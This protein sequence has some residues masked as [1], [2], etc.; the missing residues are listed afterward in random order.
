M[1]SDAADAWIVARD[2][3]LKRVADELS[4]KPSDIRSIWYLD[5][6][7]GDMSELPAMLG[8]ID[9]MLGATPMDWHKSIRE[10]ESR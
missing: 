6:S 7:D 10:A 5:E 3:F 2:E 1:A 4:T 8:V 9:R